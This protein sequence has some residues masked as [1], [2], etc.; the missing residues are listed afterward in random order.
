M[1]WAEPYEKSNTHIEPKSNF[2]GNLPLQGENN[3]ST[4]IRRLSVSH[5]TDPGSDEVITCELIFGYLTIEL[6]LH[7]LVVTTN[8]CALV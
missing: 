5:T 6:I 1:Q 2:S 4:S 3:I 8:G 7:L